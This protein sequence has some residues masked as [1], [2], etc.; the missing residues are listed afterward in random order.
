MFF[1]VKDFYFELY[2]EWEIELKGLF[3]VRIVIFNGLRWLMSFKGIIFIKMI[4]ILKDSMFMLL[5]KFIIL[6]LSQVEIY[7]LF[8]L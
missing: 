6:V 7:I 2:Y 3:F 8:M 4:Q 5:Y 1:I